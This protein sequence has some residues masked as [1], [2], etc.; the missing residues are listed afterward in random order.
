MQTHLKAKYG[1]WPNLQLITSQL[2]QEPA[3]ERSL[4]SVVTISLNTHCHGNV[5][6]ARTGGWDT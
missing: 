4:L 5:V 6:Q 1:R 3:Y 2:T